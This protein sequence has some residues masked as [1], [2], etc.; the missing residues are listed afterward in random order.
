M[1]EKLIMYY[2]RRAFLRKSGLLALNTIAATALTPALSARI[3]DAGFQGQDPVTVASDEAL[4]EPIQQAYRQS[5]DFINLENGYY[6]PAPLPVLAAQAGYIQGINETP[7]YYMRRQQEKDREAIKAKLA[8]LA[9][10]ASNELVITRNTTE[11]LDTIISG[12]DLQAG[13]E[14]IMT[15]QDYG[16]MLAAFAQQAKRYGTVNKII[17]LPLLPENDAS[18][19]SLFEQAITERTKVML[20]THMI[21]LTGQ[22]L[23]VRAICDMAR[24]KGVEVI[25]DAAH[26]FAH[27]DFHIKDLHCDYLGTSLHKWLCAPLGSGMMYIHPEKIPK[28]WPLF[29]DQDYEAHDIRK[30]EHIG[31][32]PVTTVKAIGD[33]IDFHQEIGSAYK[34]A[35]LRYMKNYW[36]NA[37][38]DLPKVRINTPMKDHQSCGIANISLEGYSPKELADALFDRYRIFTVA[39]DHQAVKGVRITPHLYTRKADLDLLIKAVKDLA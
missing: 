20:V 5:G 34:E 29:G 27:I 26:S 14:A 22:I 12:I 4:W 35:R 30:F 37:I 18:V 8:S 32:H 17:N 2:P 39:I 3:K 10:C 13:D 28:V 11:S 25:V 6:S 16:S 36:V 31:T 23:P 33:A 15:D 38:K 21:N 19:V 7:S 24:Q 1:G 9:G